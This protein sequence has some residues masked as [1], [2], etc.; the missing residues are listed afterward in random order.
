MIYLISA[1]FYSYLSFSLARQLASSAFSSSKM[2]IC[3]TYMFSLIYALHF[4]D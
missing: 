3:F 2:L 1:S 4:R